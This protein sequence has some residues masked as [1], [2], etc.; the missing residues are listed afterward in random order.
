MWR[1]AYKHGVEH[2]IPSKDRLLAEIED[3]GTDAMVARAFGVSGSTVARWR[4]HYHIPR[5][6]V[7]SRGTIK[8]DRERVRE[9]T[10]QQVPSNRQAVILGC[11]PRTIERVRRELGLLTKTQPPPVSDEVRK[12]VKA[13]LD[14]GASYIEVHRTLGVSERWL[15]RNFP[16]MG[17][18]NSQ[19]AQYRKSLDDARRAGIKL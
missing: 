17:W 13:M 19:A 4:D 1:R 7:K 16:G 12:N 2:P 3:R 18:T 6:A 10:L 8:V 15:G 5:S 14:D 9:F 11:S